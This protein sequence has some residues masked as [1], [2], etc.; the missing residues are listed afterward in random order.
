MYYLQVSVVARRGSRYGGLPRAVVAKR[1]VPILFGNSD[2]V[3][4]MVGFPLTETV[5]PGQL[6]LEQ[7][8]ARS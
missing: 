2:S 8:E 6:R 3:Q 4:K 1:S 7:F 5:G